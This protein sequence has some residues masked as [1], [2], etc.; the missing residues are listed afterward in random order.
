MPLAFQLLVMG[1]LLNYG[2][3][4]NVWGF[5]GSLWTYIG[6]YGRH[7]QGL[8]TGPLWFVK[9]LLIFSIVYALWWGLARPP[10]HKV[11]NKLVFV[12]LGLS[13]IE[14]YPLLKFALASLISLPICFVGGGLVKRLPIAGR[15][16]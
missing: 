14:L 2:L 12:S 9:A 16:L 11:R 7:Y 3:A 10:A 13:S 1:P 4:V 8:D 5:H 15:I 6:D